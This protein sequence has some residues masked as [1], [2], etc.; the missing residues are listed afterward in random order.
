M[1]FTQDVTLSSFPPSY[2]PEAIPWVL[3]IQGFHREVQQ[4]AGQLGGQHV[5]N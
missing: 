4:R 1:C 5:F 3:E 2:L